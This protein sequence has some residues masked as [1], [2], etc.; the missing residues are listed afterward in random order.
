[1]AEFPAQFPRAQCGQADSHAGLGNQRQA[2]VVPDFGRL[3]DNAAAGPCPKVFAED[4]NQEINDAHEEQRNS[5]NA[6]GVAEQ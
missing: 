6:F 2:K 3:G 5:P 1:M 4:S